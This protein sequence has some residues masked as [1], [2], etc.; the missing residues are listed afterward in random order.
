LTASEQI[1]KLIQENKLD[2]AKALCQSLFT[3]DISTIDLLQSAGLLYARLK[4][5]DTAAKFFEKALTVNPKH[6]EQHIN[7]GN[8][9][10]SLGQ[11][12]KAKQHLFEALKIDPH[13][14]EGYNNLGRLLYLENL[15][16][17]A[18]PYF[19]KALRLNPNYWEA[20][21][22]LAHALAQKNQF[23][24][25]AVHYREV[26][27]LMPEHPVANFNLGLIY[28]E[29]GNY[30]EALKYLE[31]S[32]HKEQE[33]PAS[34]YYLAH[35]HLALGH[36]PQAIEFFE[37]TLESK[38]KEN[39]GE[40]H[41]NLAVLY[42]R[43]DNHDKALYHFEQAL[44]YQPEND[45]AKHMI[46]AL[47][48]RQSEPHAPK[49]YIADLFD[50]YAEYYDSHVKEKLQY[51]VPGLL[52]NAVGRCI[53]PNSPAGRV[54][55]LG[56]GTGLCG[57]YFRDLAIELIGVD[58]SPKMAEKAKNLGAYDS[59]IVSDITDYLLNPS[60]APFDL[61]VAGDVLVYTGDLAKI[62]AAVATKLVPKGRFAFTTENIHDHTGLH[63]G[64]PKKIPNKN[65]AEENSQT[66]DYF[67]NTTGR[68]AHT[69]DYI[70]RLAETYH[71]K[72]EIEET[73]TPR[74]HEGK[75]IEGLLFV[76]QGVKSGH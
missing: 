26:I 48:G 71:F 32:L 13:H 31:H 39:R 59:V 60:L 21:Y 57:V 10:L 46:M 5:F 37:K 42:L 70:H 24:S 53:S 62:F 74:E 75:A 1:L 34:F 11:H 50:Q 63:K 19:E 40:N 72:I 68:Y 55:D 16:D 25:A 73:I 4:D 17:E 51:D 65:Q 36:I 28:F 54:L 18:I 27:R 58:L 56:C 41:H 7:L 47:K 52:R 49:Q 30:E 8:I 44:Q 66:K 38:S 3:E 2:E 29:E 12:E 20:H 14:A 61:I 23:K 9:Y 33:N 22:N 45:T 35:S 76:L 67:L 43:Q 6:V 69:A 64:I 15:F